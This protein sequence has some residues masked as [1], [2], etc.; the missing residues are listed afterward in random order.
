MKNPIYFFSKSDKFFWLSNFSPYGFEKEGYYWPTVEHYFQARK[1]HDK[2]FQEK[3]RKAN[4]PKQ[5]KVLG[6]TRN[7]KIRDDWEDIKENVMLEALREKFQDPELHERLLETGRRQLIEN[8][9]Y[10]KYWGCG[11]DGSGKNR[12]GR[13][14]MKVREELRKNQDN[15]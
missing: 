4:S 2:E 10:D 8:S 5:A 11:R 14:L 15:L 9:P 6:Q 12:L 3:I 13:L 1:F 7:I